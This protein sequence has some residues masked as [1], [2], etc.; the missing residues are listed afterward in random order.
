MNIVGFIDC[1]DS[2]VRNYRGWKSVSGSLESMGC[3]PLCLAS[4]VPENESDIFTMT[5]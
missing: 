4:I 2:F 3:C 1:F 5:P